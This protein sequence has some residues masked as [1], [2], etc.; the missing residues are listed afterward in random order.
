M[1]LGPAGNSTGVLNPDILG[2]GMAKILYGGHSINVP[3]VKI[4]ELAQAI[5]AMSNSGSYSWLTVDLDG[6]DPKR[7][8]LIMGPGIPVGIVSDQMDGHEVDLSNET[9]VSFLESASK[10]EPPA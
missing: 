1:S 2:W 5:Q 7:V 3:P 4:D 9:L 10:P 6:T 8:R